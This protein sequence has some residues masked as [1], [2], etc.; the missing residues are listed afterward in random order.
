MEE[1]Q[2][3][4]NYESLLDQSNLNSEFQ[5]PSPV[6]T[7]LLP[8]FS[9]PSDQLHKCLTFLSKNLLS[10]CYNKFP[11]SVHLSTNNF[12]QTLIQYSLQNL[13]KDPLVLLQVL[14]R[15]LNFEKLFYQSRFTEIPEQVQLSYISSLNFNFETQSN[16]PTIEIISSKPNFLFTL[17]V[18][19]FIQL[20]G[21][22]K[23]L[24]I[25]S[26]PIPYK[27]IVKVMSFCASFEEVSNRYF[28]RRA[29]KD[30]KNRL[31]A[32]LMNLSDEEVKNVQKVE[33]RRFLGYFDNF[34]QALY[35]K[36]K[37]RKIMA[38]TE[39]NLSY[40]FLTS[41]YLEKR[42]AGLV[43]ITS[44][45]PN[46]KDSPESE[47][48][49]TWI[50][51]HELLDLI[52]GSST[53][54]ELVKRSKDLV[55]FL[56]I[57]NRFDKN[58]IGKLWDCAILKH[59]TDRVAL[60]QLFSELSESFKLTDL[61]FLFSKI[62]GLDLPEIDI[63][64]LTLIKVIALASSKS[65]SRSNDL[66]KVESSWKEQEEMKENFSIIREDS[67]SYGEV[68][69]F[70]WKL[71]QESSLV[72]GVNVN[73][74]KQ[75]FLIL[76]DILST[77][78]CRG[79]RYKF[80]L[81]CIENLK[82]NTSIVTSCKLIEEIV[83]SYSDFRSNYDESKATIIKNLDREFHLLSEIFT[84][85]LLFKTEAVERIQL[86]L[87]SDKLEEARDDVCFTCSSDD[88]S[89]ESEERGKKHAELFKGLKVSKDSELNYFE[90]LKF[91]LNFIKFLFKSSSE[92]FQIKHLQVL[93]ESI[94]LN[95][96]SEEEHEIFFS[97]LSSCIDV[98][99]MGGALIN[100]ELTHFLFTDL[101]LK[102][103]ARS[104]SYEGF[105]CF[106]KIFVSLNKQHGL[107]VSDYHGHLES[108]ESNLLG[109]QYLWDLIL[110]SKQ[111]VVFRVASR[112]MLSLYKGLNQPNDSIADDFLHHISEFIS[113]GQERAQIQ[114]D[115]D[116]NP[117]ILR[118][119]IILTEFIQDFESKSDTVEIQ[120][121][122]Q[123]SNTY[124]KLFKMNVAS[125][126]LVGNLKS[127][128]VAHI[129]PVLSSSEIVLFI[130]SKKIGFR[131]ERK[132]VQELDLGSD[133][134]I[135]VYQI[136][137]EI[138]KSEESF[139]ENLET[140]KSIFQDF[141]EEILLIAL[142]NSNNNLEDA[143][144]ALVNEDMVSSMQAKVVKGKQ[145]INHS[146]RSISEI[147]SNSEIYFNM[148]FGLFELGN[149]NIS[150]RVWKL[151][152]RIPVN[153]LISSKIN[154]LD[155][156]TWK[157]ILSPVCH[158]KLLYGLN[159]IKDIV[160]TDLANEWKC[161]F[162]KQ[163]GL[164]HINKILMT[165]ARFDDKSK[166]FLVCLEN[167]IR[168]FKIFICDG[169]NDLDIEINF[170]DLT[171]KMLEIIE[172]CAS[173]ELDGTSL[174]ERTLDF[175]APLIIN[176]P[177]LLSEIYKRD[178]FNSLINYLLDSEKT[179]VR[180][181]IKFT[182]LLIVESIHSPPVNLEAPISYFLRVLLEKL[183]ENSHNH[184]D[185]YFEVLVSLIKDLPNPELL[186]KSLQTVE[187][188]LL[189]TEPF[190]DKE[191]SLLKGYINLSATLITHITP[192][193]PFLIKL[194][195]TSL[196]DSS[197]S[198]TKFSQ[199]SSKKSAFALL[200]SLCRYSSSNS[201]SL[202][203]G[204]SAYHL[205]KS[206][207]KDYPSLHSLPGRP[208]LDFLNS[209]FDS[210]IA[211]KVSGFVGLRNFG[212]TCYL[213]SLLQQLFMIKNFRK[214]IQEAEICVDDEEENLDDN[215]LYQ[216]KVVFWNLQESD[217]QFFEPSGFC[218]AFKD[219]EG[220][221]L[222][223]KQQQDVDEFF[224]LLHDKIEEGLKLSKY[225]T[226]FQTCLGGTYVHEIE[227]MEV[228]LPYK[229][230]RKEMFYRMSLDIKHKKNL[231]E[232]LDLFV[233]EDIL[234]GD[235]KYYCD[236]YDKKIPAKKR[237][238]LSDLSNTLIIHLKRFEFNYNTMQ[239][240]KINDFLEFPV[241][242][243][244][245]PWSDCSHQEDSYYL[246]ELVGVLV[247]SGGADAG[248]YYSIIKDREL[249]SWYKFDD[250]H[251]EHFDLAHLKDEC[252]GSES[253]S[254]YNYDEVTYTRT[255]N[256]Y[257]LIYQRSTQAEDLQAAQEDQQGLFI[258]PSEQ[259]RLRIKK[260]NMD[261]L[262]DKFLFSTSYMNFL[263]DLVASQKSFE[264][265]EVCKELS[266]TQDLHKR[267]K[268]GLAV[269]QDIKATTFQ[270][271]SW[272]ELES[273]PEILEAV[274]LVNGE[275]MSINEKR[276]LN[277]A[278]G[279]IATIYAF[280][281][282]LRARQ[283]SNFVT[284]IGKLI[285][286]YKSNPG[287]ALWLLQFLN[288]NTG[289]L[290]E[291]LIASKDEVKTEFKAL[292]VIVIHE[293]S[294]VESNYL[295]ETFQ[296]LSLV[297]LA[298]PCGEEFDLFSSTFALESEYFATTTR[299]FKMFLGTFLNRAANNSKS[300]HEYFTVLKVLSRQTKVY[301]VFSHFKTALALINH[302]FSDFSAFQ[303][304]SCYEKIIC[305]ETA[306]CLVRG[307]VTSA[308]VTSMSFPEYL[309]CPFKC[310]HL[311]FLEET[312]LTNSKIIEKLLNTA[313]IV[314]SLNI[315]THLTW[316]NR[317]ASQIAIQ[318]F[319]S[320]LFEVKYEQNRY[321]TYLKVGYYLLTIEDSL[322]S[323][324]SDLLFSLPIIKNSEDKEN[325]FISHWFRFRSMHF[326]N[327]VLI[328]LSDVIKFEH[329][330]QSLLPQS[331]FI[332]EI[333]SSGGLRS[334][335][336][337]YYWDY[338]DNS[339]HLSREVTRLRLLFGVQESEPELLGNNN[340]M[341]DTEDS[342]TES[343]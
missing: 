246:Y 288:E 13:Q 234:D 325:N 2:I 199:E 28:W 207:L 326:F 169:M 83:L 189:T 45:I 200:L 212:A 29:C 267:W 153:P 33:F 113:E 136:S 272:T 121:K 37:S 6:L 330:H 107:I 82:K 65:S 91:R 5:D 223:V 251:I 259:I 188:L 201:I 111:K 302:F 158:H 270:A 120:V 145:D 46:F 240:T 34:L 338:M 271:S 75:S 152:T 25:V 216:L 62:L 182:I 163:G 10:R 196:I 187:S 312:E 171:A 128:I 32:K 318:K 250:K 50:E 110:K 19:L 232:A 56:Y 225:R 117:Q 319:I 170:P 160:A 1:D 297:N 137:K 309:S 294:S 341:V 53:H 98:W 279:K 96:V 335:N 11:S 144:N 166:S 233:K 167:L 40:R 30:L 141:D 64:T 103:D 69:E 15:V 208:E 316:E 243:D 151:L 244:L 130:G 101:F 241:N 298:E 87:S 218:K 203:Q 310:P 4:S 285:T 311:N 260:E 14:L 115:L 122:N 164:D 228:D 60:I 55:K 36:D 109:I 268:I 165:S 148:L 7:A 31:L 273:R 9:N 155:D 317:E 23:I 245:K 287:L 124:P 176:Q 210:D 108:K 184:C 274:I 296:V 307:S 51:S 20:Q 106:E 73:V 299:F 214:G 262:R 213:N 301:T 86:Q 192:E 44:K 286:V 154:S 77:Y 142:E 235:N 49:I 42:I 284:W 324:R 150:N 80:L 255:R 78:N 278:L 72:A 277:D 226:L 281:V 118:S 265:L 3:L 295:L 35:S 195:Y 168:T 116:C 321:N 41:K 258:N 63:S 139:M 88:D 257:M 336:N 114:G 185:E 197:T 119:V 337:I 329:V 38:G 79:D 16:D 206:I 334:E 269:A 175:L 320:S 67:F 178:S 156:N 315:L 292:L 220:L 221:P 93:W 238:L 68:L 215:L 172:N 76:K 129:D 283:S 280:E 227:S 252:F 236:Q 140:L 21:F 217:K 17:N 84:S 146:S 186:Q 57:N 190:T 59:E 253:S 74:C 332:Q 12:L 181:S 90:E 328:W 306:A 322:K 159:I 58:N 125:K 105:K 104:V 193:C 92:T 219:Y 282:L 123:V 229:S 135:I 112:L 26:E 249:L 222:N 261:F 143:V 305:I 94:V 89:H 291:V 180:E 314:D 161:K 264:N 162:V 71:C 254:N 22:D 134:Y 209:N 194:I 131:L 276:G 290:F 102:L 248:H 333:L 132:T 61:Q 323:F 247:H 242:L 289:I 173:K 24:A 127:L 331:G 275:R 204:L 231:S 230:E 149:E 211:A 304:N 8:H 327:A 224:N 85:F 266:L 339:R 340:D 198:S 300:A 138:E 303:M 293:A 177:F 205:P 183:P 342:G 47:F 99:F 52:F 157:S 39:L 343:I 133:S 100:E 308:M 239:R 48:L 237:C 18:H 43:D 81:K 191:E 263:K 66:E 174:I 256:A 70:L 147:L 27:Y 126:T 313:K 97:W 54:P 95:A 202:L 179:K